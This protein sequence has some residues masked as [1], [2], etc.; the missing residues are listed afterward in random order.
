MIATPSKRISTI[1]RLFICYIAVVIITLPGSHLIARITDNISASNNHSLV[2]LIHPKDDAHI[3]MFS[4]NEK[5]AQFA[6]AALDAETRIRGFFMDADYQ[7]ALFSHFNGNHNQPTMAWV[8]KAEQLKKLVLDNKFNLTIQ[9]APSSEM[10]FMMSAF[11]SKGSNGQS[12]ALLNRNWIDYGITHEAF[13]RLIIEQSGF[14]I[15]QFLN[16]AND[17]KGNEGKH[18]ANDLSSIYEEASTAIAPGYLTLG[19]RRVL[20]EN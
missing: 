1:S 19:G 9:L 16:G 15:D 17:T 13:T 2:S 5:S 8:K 12:L 20:V 6:E 3:A 10:D 11:I 7:S 14:A 4:T 18:F